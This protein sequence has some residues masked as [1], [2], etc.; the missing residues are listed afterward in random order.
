MIASILSIPKFVQSLPRLVTNFGIGTLVGMAREATSDDFVDYRLVV[1]IV[2]NSLL[3]HIVVSLVRVTTSY[4]AVELDLPVVWIG[5]IAATF[6][7]FPIFLAVWV[8]RFIDRGNDAAAV[9]IGSGL[10]TL[11][12]LG[13]ALFPSAAGLLAC[14]ALIG[15]GHLFMHSAQ[16]LLCVR[17]GGAGNMDRVFGNYM[18][19]AAVG[20]G[21]GPFVVGW[22]GG[23]AT[24]P[25][26]GSLFWL[27][28]AMAAV[29]F[30][31]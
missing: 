4:R 1:P 17:A 29:T 3:I 8:G 24:L 26:T 22:A 23:A 25:P 14:T 9:W 27:A 21:I 18:L 28:S 6:A 11:A 12:C 19:A 30:L 5:A 31:V 10:I 13:F 7:L 15:T 2:A 16:Q 20:Q